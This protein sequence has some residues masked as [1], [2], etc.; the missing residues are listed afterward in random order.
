MKWTEAIDVTSTD[1]QFCR[2]DGAVESASCVFTSLCACDRSR[3]LPLN[4]TIAIMK[5]KKENK[6]KNQVN[7]KMVEFKKS[8]LVPF[9]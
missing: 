8:L 2:H 6:E 5:K 9:T 3:K 4:S 7:G 1:I